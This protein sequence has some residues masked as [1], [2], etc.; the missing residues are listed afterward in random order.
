MNSA[1]FFHLDDPAA[2]NHLSPSASEWLRARL[3]EADA[4]AADQIQGTTS[5]AQE[6]S[7]GLAG[8]LAGADDDPAFVFAGQ[9]DAQEAQSLA[10]RLCRSCA[11]NTRCPEEACRIF[12]VEAAAIAYQANPSP[13]AAI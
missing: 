4:A 9:G 10:G 12:R 1:D 3:A 2:A 7:P 6:V 8:E 5:L 13:D 11:L